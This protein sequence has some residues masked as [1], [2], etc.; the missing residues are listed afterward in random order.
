MDMYAQG[1]I[2]TCMIAG[3]GGPAG[4]TVRTA[5]AL[6]TPSLVAVTDAV[7]GPTPVTAAEPVFPPTALAVIVAWPGPT[8]VT[9]PSIETVATAAS[10]DVHPT[11]RTRTLPLAS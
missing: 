10:L 8:A 9:A 4:T 7:P 5:G 2:S 11:G 6:R 3:G 1:T